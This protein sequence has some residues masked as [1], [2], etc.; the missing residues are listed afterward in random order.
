MSEA[1][2]TDSELPPAP[3]VAF[4]G[5]DENLRCRDFQY[6]VGKTYSF[7]GTIKLCENGAHACENPLDVWNYYGPCDARYALVESGGN[8]DRNGD[9]D[10][11]I[12]CAEI[13]IKAEL[14]LPEFIKR[15]VAYLI[16]LAKTD[17]PKDS[18]YYSQL[19]ASGD[20]SQ[21][22][23]SGGSSKLA[24]SGDYSKLAASGYYSQLVASSDYSQLAASGYSS[25]LAASGDYSKLEITGQ[26]GVAAIAARNGQVRG[27]VGTW[28]SV[29][30]FNDEG[31]C[32]CFVSVCIGE[33]GTKPDTWYSANGG[34]LVEVE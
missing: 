8:I 19:A 21:L 32:I 30:E 34:K 6:E 12:A 27:V 2:T 13:T 18:G 1:E 33:D 26:N 5:F 11:K 17:I 20:Y 14:K 16:D 4:K 7:N 31:K 3:L 9:G 15:A 28:V 24:A 10:T 29:A 23:A 22:A 25:K